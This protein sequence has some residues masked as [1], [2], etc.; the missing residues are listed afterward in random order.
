MNSAPNRLSLLSAVQAITDGTLTA[1]QLTESCLERIAERDESVGAWIYLAED[2]AR[3][4]AT[5]VH[6]GP[7]CG[8]PI[9]IKDLIDTHEMP[10][11]YGSSIYKDYRPGWDAACVVALRNAGGIVLGKTVS[12]EFAWFGPGKTA[13]PH[14]PTRTPGGSS[15]GSAAAVADFQ[16]P[17]ALGT[18]TAGSIIRP[19]SFCGVVGYKPTYGLLPLTG[20]RPLSPS[21]DHMGVFAR[22]VQDAGFLA[23]IVGRRP[24]LRVSDIKDGWTPRIG[25]CRTHEWG[26]AESET[27]ALLV[28]AAEALSGAGA[29]IVDISLPRTFADL[30]EAQVTVMNYEVSFSG[31]Y[32]ATHYRDQVSEKY[33][34]C[35]ESGMAVT[36]E[37]YDCA[38]QKTVMARAELDNVMGECDVLLCPSAPG[39]APVGLLG[40]GDPI[41]NRAWTLLGLPCVNVPGLT[42]PNGMPVGV[43]LVGRLGD[44][45]KVLQAASWVHAQLINSVN[46]GIM[47]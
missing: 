12:T 25:F 1:E 13:N 23:S 19:A 35:F 21:M 41:F 29:P 11:G 38:V 26:F 17:A 4:A 36:P 14:D 31:L 33:I 27:Q 40:T 7:L 24:S 44:D 37:M 32:E 43:Q 3:A 10:T 22:S 45:A 2:D 6:N 34:E 46:K 42:G 20:V 30:S 47:I 9:G 15:S 8:V 39:E 5:Q 28:N 18:Q 16:V